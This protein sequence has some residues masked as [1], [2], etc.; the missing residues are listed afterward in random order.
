MHIDGGG[1]ETGVKKGVVRK[2]TTSGR[3]NSRCIITMLM[4][5]LEVLGG[6]HSHFKQVARERVLSSV[7]RPLS[8]YCIFFFIAIF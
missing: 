3:C 4:W 8:L 2:R 5:Y 7:A 1:G 6:F